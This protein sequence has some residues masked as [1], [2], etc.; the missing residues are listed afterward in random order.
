MIV[1]I[2]TWMFEPCLIY[3]LSLSLISVC[4]LMGVPFLSWHYYLELR[5]T[6]LAMLPRVRFIA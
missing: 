1:S 6:N 3:I 2:P 4:L 5:H